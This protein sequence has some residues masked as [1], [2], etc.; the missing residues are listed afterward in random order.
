MN[1][2]VVS[3]SGFVGWRGSGVGEPGAGAEAAS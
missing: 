2:T 1:A 3:Y